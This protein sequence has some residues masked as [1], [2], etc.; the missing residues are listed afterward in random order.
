MLYQLSQKSIHVGSLL[1]DPVNVKTLKITE[2]FCTLSITIC[3]VLHR[4]L[5]GNIRMGDLN[6]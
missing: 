2:K 3:Y 6:L 1:S 4:S 5:L